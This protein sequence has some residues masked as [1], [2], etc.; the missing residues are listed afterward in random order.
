MN[1][2]GYF[3]GEAEPNYF[4]N[5]ASDIT[6][7]SD[8]ERYLSRKK[9]FEKRKWEYFCNNLHIYLTTL[10][11][12]IPPNVKMTITLQRNSD[13]F[14]LGSEYVGDANVRMSCKIWE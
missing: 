10:R 14:C 5:N 1:D 12:V 2:K 4:L 8:N 11:K 9:M 13:E 6:T 7:E 3:Q